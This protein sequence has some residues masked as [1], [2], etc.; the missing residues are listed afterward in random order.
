MKEL[1]FDQVEI[2]SGAGWREAACVSGFT[3][4]GTLGGFIAGGAFFTMGAGAFWG[5]TVGYHAGA[6]ICIP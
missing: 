6:A 1:K 3:A 4:L 2:V 5:A